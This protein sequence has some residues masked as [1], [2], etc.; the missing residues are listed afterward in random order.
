[1]DRVTLDHLAV[2]ARHDPEARSRLIEFYLNL[3]ARWLCKLGYYARGQA[4]DDLVQEAVIGVIHA[5]AQYNPEMGSFSRLAYVR[6]RSRLIDAIR[7]GKPAFESLSEEHEGAFLPG[8]AVS[9]SVS[10]SANPLDILV[11]RESSQEQAR[12]F[13]RTRFS[14]LEWRVLCLLERGLKPSQIAGALGVPRKSV[15]HALGRVR[16]KILRASA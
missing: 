8:G 6:I 7:R 11:A 12:L 1:M 3:I 13:E 9:G 5:I 16:E 15:Y 10:T 2:Q 4:P 14:D